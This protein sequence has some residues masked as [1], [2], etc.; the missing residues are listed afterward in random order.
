MRRATVLLAF[1]EIPRRAELPRMRLHDLRH[2]ANTILAGRRVSRAER[3]EQLGHSETSRLTDRTYLRVTEDTQAASRTVWGQ[4]LGV[5][6]ATA[7]P[8][9]ERGI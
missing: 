6:K 5:C 2:K 1:Q 7:R 9:A 8:G 3:G 4:V